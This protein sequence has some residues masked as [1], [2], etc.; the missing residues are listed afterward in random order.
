MADCISYDCT[1]DL[2]NHL[3]N[4][5]GVESLGGLKDIIILE[6]NHT[7]TDP[8]DGTEVL[9]EIAAG[10]ATLIKN[11]K[12]GVPAASP[13]KS[14]ALIACSSDT[15][16]NYDRTLNWVDGNMNENNIQLYNNLLGGQVK[17]GAILHGCGTDEVTWINSPISFEGSRVIPDTDD[18]AQHFAIT[19]M[20]KEVTEGSIYSTPVGVF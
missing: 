5:C 17:G 9:A 7:L 15:V 11:V 6:C 3:L 2:G 18:D 12:I 16:R 14:A 20:W 10:T 4:T 13:I 19:G 1:D 8:S